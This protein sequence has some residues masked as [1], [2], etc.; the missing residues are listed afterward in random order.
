MTFILQI[1]L[2]MLFKI[3]KNIIDKLW[4]IIY[5]ILLEPFH[6]IWKIFLIEH[7]NDKEKWSEYTVSSIISIILTILITA[8]TLFIW[9]KWDLKLI[10]DFYNWNFIKKDISNFLDTK[11]TLVLNKDCKKL[12]EM[13]EKYL[14]K[15]DLWKKEWLN[16][17]NENI[18]KILWYDFFI[19]RYD[20]VESNIAEILY[21]EII[22]KSIDWKVKKIFYEWRY[23][24]KKIDWKWIINWATKN[25]FK[26]EERNF[27]K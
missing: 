22:D 15:D 12:A 26:T 24:L 19:Y 23:Y 7:K 10:S 1:D 16:Q 9:I 20:K 13:E 5:H 8:I 3:L 25:N 4:L 2:K 14:L 18:S 17:C 21:F 27:D 11:K 6:K